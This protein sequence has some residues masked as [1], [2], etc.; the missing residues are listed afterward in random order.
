MSDKG[1]GAVVD[2]KMERADDPK[3][4]DLAA[5]FEDLVFEDS[6]NAQQTVIFFACLINSEY[7]CVTVAVIL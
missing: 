3:P 7:S 4:D 2:V 5:A 1:S 6:F